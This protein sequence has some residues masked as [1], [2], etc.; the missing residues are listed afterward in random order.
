M[1][2]I[3]LLFLVIPLGCRGG[4]SS[5]TL[6]P[7][8]GSNTLQPGSGQF[9]EVQTA[10]LFT[11][12]EP[13]NTIAN[14]EFTLGPNGASDGLGGSTYSRL[15]P[16]GYVAALDDIEVPPP[17]DSFVAVD[18]IAISV[19]DGFVVR[20]ADGCPFRL[21]IDDIQP[22]N[23]H[24]LQSSGSDV[25][26]SYAYEDCAA[27][28]VTPTTMISNPTCPTGESPTGGLYIS[29]DNDGWP[30]NVIY[31]TPTQVQHYPRGSRVTLSVE[32]A[33]EGAP[34][35][36]W[37]QSCVGSEDCSLTMDTDKIVDVDLQFTQLCDQQSGG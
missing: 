19:G 4:S 13:G 18:Q 22:D 1:Y 32:G 14:G 20:G 30:N 11:V 15:A 5:N 7:D 8:G 9:L 12:F 29:V 16:V 37:M 21:R 23:Q 25:T 17:L 3:A 6:Q 28:T 36:T 2:R 10:V 34:L 35:T 26:V 31:T 24:G 27:L 33:V